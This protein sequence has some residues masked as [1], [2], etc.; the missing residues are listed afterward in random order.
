MVGAHDRLLRMIGGL[1]V[2]A[3]R[4]RTL[5][6]HLA[7]LVGRLGGVWRHLGHIP[8]L[9]MR[10]ALGESGT[11]ARPV[12]RQ[13]PAVAA[14]AA[15][16]GLH[17]LI[18]VPDGFAPALDGTAQLAGIVLCR[19][20]V[21]GHMP[22]RACLRILCLIRWIPLQVVFGAAARVVDRSQRVHAHRPGALRAQRALRA[23]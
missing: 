18:A 3:L 14:P 20:G 8:L 12:G 9:R 7:I 22:N 21:L 6:R 23:R 15:I 17:T 1:V 11:V 19:I 2:R 16:D 5:E 10:A 13:A 4:N